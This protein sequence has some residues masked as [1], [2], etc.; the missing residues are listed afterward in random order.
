MEQIKVKNTF[1][2]N[3]TLPQNNGE[4]LFWLPLMDALRTQTMSGLKALVSKEQNFLN[5]SIV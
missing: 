4:K 5:N 2:Y 3:N 1:N